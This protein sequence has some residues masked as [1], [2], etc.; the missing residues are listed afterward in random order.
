[1]FELENFM[2]I[3]KQVDVRLTLKYFKN[4]SVYGLP[5]T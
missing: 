2:T 1:M 5:E 4:A 3:R